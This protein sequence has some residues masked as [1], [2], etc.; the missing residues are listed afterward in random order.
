[1]RLAIFNITV[2][3]FFGM[4][5]NTLFI[6]VLLDGVERLAWLL[7]LAIILEFLAAV[8]LIVTGIKLM[9]K[10]LISGSR[11]INSIRFG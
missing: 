9:I 4:G 6:S 1:M 5:V 10:D 11:D 2:G 8:I 7:L 3:L